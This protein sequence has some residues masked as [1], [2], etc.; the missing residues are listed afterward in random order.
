MFFIVTTLVNWPY[1]YLSPCEL[2]WGRA[3]TA[4][5]VTVPHPSNVVGDELA[6]LRRHVCVGLRPGRSHFE[7][8]QV[9]LSPL[10][11][12]R[13]TCVQKDKRVFESVVYEC[14]I[15][16]LRIRQ[17]CETKMVITSSVTNGCSS[18]RNSTTQT[19]SNAGPSKSATQIQ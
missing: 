11:K 19:S 9:A 7:R 18:I 14:M 17:A 15:N 3:D 16:E 2:V 6:N 1:A 4:S 8:K 5:V 10:C 12:Q 13:A